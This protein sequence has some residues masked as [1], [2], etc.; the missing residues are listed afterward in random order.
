[1][2]CFHRLGV[3]TILGLG[4]AAG[5]SKGDS[6]N[7]TSATTNSAQNYVPEIAE[8]DPNTNPAAKAAH[9]FLGAMLKGDTQLTSSFVTP[10]AM[11]RIAAS[12]MQFSP[13]GVDNATFKIGGAVTVVRSSF[14]GSS[15]HATWVLSGDAAMPMMTFGVP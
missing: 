2:N 6:A 3:V 12:G 13:P 15:I 5:C 14:I 9:G 11:Q 4:L 8:T 1:M 10:Q 7:N